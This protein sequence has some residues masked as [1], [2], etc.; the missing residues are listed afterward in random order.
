MMFPIRINVLSSS[1]KRHLRRL[2]LFT[3]IK[4]ACA[5]FFSLLGIL[6][7][8][9]VITQKFFIEYRTDLSYNPLI[10]HP[11]YHRDANRIDD[12]N[13]KIRLTDSFQQGYTLWSE[14]IDTILSSTPTGITIE[15][16]SF[17]RGTNI[18]S[19]V[20]TASTRESLELYE[21]S[22]R[23]VPILNSVTIPQGELTRRENIPFTVTATLQ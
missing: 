11:S 12:A 20:G 22:L 18:V 9:L 15:S 13:K 7:T 21:Q 1:K 3:Y 4:T 17:D 16:A 6:A 2:T 23:F 19:L 14:V 10:G 5:L 8:I